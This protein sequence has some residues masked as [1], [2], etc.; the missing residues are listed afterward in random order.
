MRG[1]LALCAEFYFYIVAYAKMQK[2]TM[3]D[4]MG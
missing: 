2:R 1:F 3:C 4:Y